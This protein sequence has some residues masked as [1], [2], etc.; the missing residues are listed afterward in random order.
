MHFKKLKNLLG[1]ESQF[2]KDK[3][4]KKHLGENVYFKDGK[5]MSLDHGS[6]T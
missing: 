6:P 5:I 3:I 2:L 4:F 1:E